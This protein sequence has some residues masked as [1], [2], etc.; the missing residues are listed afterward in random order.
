[1]SW[2]LEG[3]WLKTHRLPGQHSHLPGTPRHVCRQTPPIPG[4]RAAPHPR[5]LLQWLKGATG[6]EARLRSRGKD[7]LFE[8]EGGTSRAIEKHACGGQRPLTA[9]SSPPPPSAT[10]PSS[11]LTSGEPHVSGQVSSTQGDDPSPCSTGV[12]AAMPAKGT[13]RPLA[14][15]ATSR[16]SWSVPHLLI[17][18]PAHTL[19]L[20]H[21]DLPMAT[22]RVPVS[23]P[24]QQEASV[25]S[26]AALRTSQ[27][28][29][30]L[31]HGQTSRHHR[32]PSRW[33]AASDALP[34]QAGEAGSRREA[35][36]GARGLLSCSPNLWLSWCFPPKRNHLPFQKIPQGKHPLFPAYTFPATAGN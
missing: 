30:T 9:S 4:P 27:H 21:L 29:C 23:S 36:S 5:S 6:H 1:M 20:P 22:S 35:C 8:T 12:G 14:Q 28:L 24:N 15:Q 13:R 7:V 17:P 2:S 34:R 32:P 26:E 10:S 18:P 19:A 16:R 33:L 25:H 3:R 31:P 11:P